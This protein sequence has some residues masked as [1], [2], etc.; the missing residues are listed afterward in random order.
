MINNK[1]SNEKSA[2]N[3]PGIK[4][5]PF[6]PFVIGAYPLVFLYA[7]NQ[8]R[9]SSINE[10]WPWLA[11]TLGIIAVLYLSLRLLVRD[12]YKSDFLTAFISFWWLS[13][14][15]Y[16]QPFMRLMA[17]LQ[18]SPSWQTFDI[19]LKVFWISG[20]VAGIFL[21][22]RQKKFLKELDSLLTNTAFI[23]LIISVFSISTCEFERIKID[24]QL[25]KIAQE[26]SPLVKQQ[27]ERPNIYF[28]VLDTYPRSDELKRNFGFDNTSFI[29]QLCDR[30]FFVDSASWSNYCRTGLSLSSTL[31]LNYLQN[32]ALASNSEPVTN[33]SMET[34]DALAFKLV[35]YS[36]VSRF[37][38]QRGYRYIAVSSYIT[39][40]A[41][42][43]VPK[44]E[45]SIRTSFENMAF[46][47]LSL[48]YMT[49]CLKIPGVD[50]QRALRQK[51][52]LDCIDMVKDADDKEAP[53][54][55]FG[56]IFAPHPP[57]VFNK[58]G[59]TAMGDLCAWDG[60]EYFKRAS[61]DRELYKAQFV[62]QLQW[63]NQ[64]ALELV[65][66]IEKKSRR[67]TIIIIEG[68][69]GSGLNYDC[70]LLEKT[71]VCERFGN[72]LSIRLPLQDRKKIPCFHTPINIFRFI[73]TKYFNQN[74]ELLPE[75][76]YYSS[77]QHPLHF[78]D[79]SQKLS[80]CSK[81]AIGKR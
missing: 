73:F 29:R 17:N 34:D 5:I 26:S 70:D 66:S 32:I 7:A 56:H 18:V 54:F 43:D 45:F 1:P 68:D 61:P 42:A 27:A 3:T 21:I 36:K 53:V 41:G 62:E 64:K 20:F 74:Y 8:Q 38:K 22:L 35:E 13:L 46:E 65:D 57:F 24:E 71:D 28:I 11:A 16:A 14:E 80:E 77:V 15:L 63:V 52:L 76:S 39:S 48:K 81:T 60:C 10:L 50:R 12:R 69:H 31:N 47:M 25:R 30:G 37:L 51:S 59:S 58:D 6:Y 49:D 40:F 55:V 79:I 78:I 67:P 4:W 19:L 23:L 9:I 33:N 44:T 75:K 72:L 2:K